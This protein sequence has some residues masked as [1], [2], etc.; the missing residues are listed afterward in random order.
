M[1]A[2][3]G[4]IMPAI[5]AAHM[6]QSSSRYVPSHVAVIIQ[7]AEPVMGP[8]MSRAIRMTHA[9]HASGTPMRSKASVRR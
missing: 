3:D 8:Y 7:A 4:S 2:A 9:Q 5:M 1:G 6:A